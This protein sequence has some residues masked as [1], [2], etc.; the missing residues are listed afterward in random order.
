MIKFIIY[1]NDLNRPTIT[2]ISVTKRSEEIK[3]ILLVV[4]YDY[5]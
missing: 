5:K 2:I 4:I 3:R 1:V